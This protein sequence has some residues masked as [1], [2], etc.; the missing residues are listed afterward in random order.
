MSRGDG[1]VPLADLH[2][3]LLP[4][5]DDGS[6]GWEVT[7]Q[8]L[9]ILAE[10]DVKIVAPTPHVWEQNWH[11]IEGRHQGLRELTDMAARFGIKI[12]SAAEVWAMPDLPERWEKVLPLTYAGGGKYLL[13]EFDVAEMPLYTE[14]F[15]FQLRVR[16][17]TPIIAHPERYFWVQEDERNLFRLLANGALLQVSADTLVRP[18][19]PAGRTAWWLL[20]NG[21]V[22][23]LA[24][25]WHNPDSPY[26]L[27]LAVQKLK[28]TLNE[29]E[30]ER[31]VW[32]VPMKI[33]SGQNAQPAWQRSPLRLEIQAFIAGV[34][35]PPQ[36]RRW[37]QLLTFWR[38][39]GESKWR[40]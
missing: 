7:E 25:D 8:M 26:P 16:G 33:V 35:R 39:E 37:W 23:F 29:S 24:S 40:K 18:D 5:V 2:I 19:T 31:L 20:Q 32:T 14:W 21:L 15:L 38:R 1:K 10:K 3:H 28:S 11:D 12:V 9:K 34:E 30:I 22:D 4:G 6:T 17:V 36:K 27:T 13:V